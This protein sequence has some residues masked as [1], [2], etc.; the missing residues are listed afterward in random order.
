MAQAARIFV[1]HAHADSA[2]CRA[3]VQALRDAG[4]DVWYDEHDLTYAFIGEEIVHELQERPTFIVLHSPASL[5]SPWVQRE[6]G[7]A[8]GLGEKDRTRSILLVT[9]EQADVPTLWA[10]FQRVSGPGDRGLS[11]PEAARRVISI[12]A[13]AP[14]H[15]Q[16]R[17]PSR[18]SALRLA[19]SQN[20]AR[21]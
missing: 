16:E 14:A 10:A 8:I 20:T 15:T 13:H 11:A 7:T 21:V 1:S 18:R 9:A 4:A 12:L 2:W 6:V 17:L 5:A 3:F 19:R